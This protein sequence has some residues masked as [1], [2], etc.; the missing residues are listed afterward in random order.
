[1]ARSSRKRKLEA[2]NGDSNNQ[3]DILWRQIE[4]LVHQLQ[5]KG[6]TPDI[7]PEFRKIRENQ[8]PNIDT[9]IREESAAQQEDYNVT[10]Q[11]GSTAQQDGYNGSTSQPED[12]NITPQHE[13]NKGK[14]NTIK[15]PLPG[16][17][18]FAMSIQ[19]SASPILQRFYIPL[20]K[21]QWL[22]RRYDFS[23]SAPHDLRHIFHVLSGKTTFSVYQDDFQ[24]TLRDDIL[25]SFCYIGSTVQTNET[26][27]K[28]LRSYGSLLCGCLCLCDLAR[29][30][31]VSEVNNHYNTYLQGTFSDDYLMR[32]RKA[33]RWFTESISKMDTDM[34]YLA[35]EVLFFCE[36][37]R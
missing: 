13:S 32:L 22:K 27:V 35:W 31:D 8:N 15:T 16:E 36:F 26:V 19:N 9:H 10:R 14:R 28:A 18:S 30:R 7:L 34:S 2:S 1:M 21:I 11:H 23:I 33:S 24:L 20:N 4:L 25:E 6:I 12:C 29:K 17:S 3:V 37:S 5:E